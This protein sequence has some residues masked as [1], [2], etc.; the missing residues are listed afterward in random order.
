MPASRTTRASRADLLRLRRLAQAIDGPREPDPAAVARR[1]LAVQGQDFA[2][3]CWALALRTT[4]ATQSDVLADL[5]A[6]RIIRSWPMRGTLHFVPPED[7]RWML[8][9]T[10][11]RMVAGLGRRQQQL[12][13]EAADF[14][15]A[16]D[17]VTAALTGGR[18]LSRTEAMELWESAGIA[19]TGQRGY[20]LIYFLAQTGLLCWGPVVRS[21]NGNP[22]QALVL[23]DEWAPAPAALEPDEAVAQFLLRYLAGHGPATVRDFVWWTKGTVA[24]A[25]TALGV[26]GDTVTTLESDGVEYLVTRE[27]ADRGAASPATRSEKDAVHLLPGFDEYL[28][29]YQDRSPILDD[30]HAELIVPGNNGIFQPIIVAGGRIVGTWRRDG[31]NVVPL[32]FASLT[33]TRLTRLQRAAKAYSRYAG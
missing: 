9:V 6:G 23:L 13:L 25:K 24:G 28:L 22:A 19:T 26:L 2:A 7:L 10:M 16:A 18:S 29:G 11:D 12:G 4:G 1:L 14:A 5:D 8:S 21:G 3:G 27:L 30:E 31:S 20:H 32:P 15:R 17:V 33:D